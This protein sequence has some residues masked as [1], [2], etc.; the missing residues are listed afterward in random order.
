M[1]GTKNVLYHKE[2]SIYT[3]RIVAYGII[4]EGHKVY[5]LKN[6]SVQI[7]FLMNI[8][9]VQKWKFEE[10]VSK[11]AGGVASTIFRLQAVWRTYR[12]AKSNIPPLN[13]LFGGGGYKKSLDIYIQT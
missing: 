11:A 1:T 6:V 5:S 9:V 10:N 3:T 12:Q 13:V 2:S 4:Y 8:E 7:P